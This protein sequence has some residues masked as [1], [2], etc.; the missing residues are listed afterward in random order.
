VG[1]AEWFHACGV[2]L[3]E[4]YGLAE[5]CG[6]THLNTPEAY[7]FGT[8][9]RALPGVLTRIADDGEIVLQGPM[10]DGELATGDLGYVDGDGYLVVRRRRA[11]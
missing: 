6:V 1:V 4:G 9:G 5:A 10:I 2:L 7:R 11:R 8:A 3:L